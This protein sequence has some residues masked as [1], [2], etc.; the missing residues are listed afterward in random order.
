MPVSIVHK[1]SADNKGSCS[2]YG[3]YLNKENQEYF[4]ADQPEKQQM[5]F[6]NQ[7]NNISTVNA[8]DLIDRNTK[9]KGLKK[10][11]DKYFT[12]TLNFSDKELK[13]IAKQVSNKSI[14][15]VDD[16][17]I[18]EYQAYNKA[19]RDYTRKAM[20][21]YADNFNKEI[22]VNDIVWTAKIEHQRKFK[23][24]DEQVIKGNAKSGQLKPGLNTHVHITVSRMH[25]YYRI[26]LSP[27]ANA[28]SSKNLVLNGK[29]IKGGFDRS[30]WKQLN[31]DT[32]DKHF[33]YNR[34]LD[35]KFKTLNILKNGSLE[36]KR[37]IKNQ[38]ELEHKSSSKTQQLEL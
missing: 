7:H 28:R 34:A 9:G 16:L 29:S 19:V 12:V 15:T 35:E 27:L 8:I 38:I 10:T 5:F 32:F 1:T 4:K 37:E 21:N 26:S 14:N 31:E 11:Q 3:F 36:K 13:H 18:N 17:N 20:K 24:E 6:T 25:K 23:G 22:K 33:N 30:N 2:K